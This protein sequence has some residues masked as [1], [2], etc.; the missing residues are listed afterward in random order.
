MKISSI[1]INT[2]SEYLHDVSS[3]SAQIKSHNSFECLRNII[4]IF[5]TLGPCRP[6]HFSENITYNTSRH[7]L[8]KWEGA[9]SSGS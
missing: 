2:F 3:I 5:L 9:P 4:H 1:L 8:K 6:I 7:F